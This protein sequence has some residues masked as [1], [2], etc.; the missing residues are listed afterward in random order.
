MIKFLII[1]RLQYNDIIFEINQMEFGRRNFAGNFKLQCIPE[2]MGKSILDKTLFMDKSFEPVDEIVDFGCADGTLIAFLMQMDSTYK[3]IGYDN[4]PYMIEK[5]KENVP[6]MNFFDNWDHIDCNYHKALINI[7]SVVHEIYSYLDEDGIKEF[8]HRVFD[9]GFKYICIR[10]MM[11]SKEDNSEVPAADI[12]KISSAEAYSEK[13]EEHEKVWG[14]IKDRKNLI[15]FLLK[16][17]WNDN[18]AREV[19]ENYLGL[20][21]EEFLNIIPDGY[22]IEYEDRFVL[23]YLKWCVKKISES[24]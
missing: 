19:R 7:S 6:N 12:Q 4:V 20:E 11:F 1:D 18:W 8:W 22:E 2:N 3:Y 23:S 17:Q 24:S 9:S 21:Y 10:D 5:A 15:H 13:L 16:Y 14:K